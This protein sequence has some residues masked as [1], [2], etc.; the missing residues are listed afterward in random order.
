MWQDR[1]TKFIKQTFLCLRLEKVKS[2]ALP[3]PGGG[4]CLHCLV[5][6]NM[7]GLRVRFGVLLSFLT[8]AL[9]TGSGGGCVHWTPP[10]LDDLVYH[11][12]C[13]SNRF[14]LPNSIYAA[15]RSKAAPL[16][17]LQMFV[18]VVSYCF[19]DTFVSV[20]VFSSTVSIF[21]FA[22]SFYFLFIP[23]PLPGSRVPFPCAFWLYGSGVQ[24]FICFLLFPYQ[25]FIL[26]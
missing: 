26:R 12:W 3:P 24:S 16:C 10:F 15:D 6:M 19:G 17:V 22:P 9:V 25:F 5:Y 20:V 18:Y 14:K 1:P 11:I 21:P 8:L 13:T 4:S 7:V 23:S 2:R